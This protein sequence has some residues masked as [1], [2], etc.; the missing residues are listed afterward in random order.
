M[1]RRL[2]R[3][4][5]FALALAGAGPA[6]AAAF[7][8]RAEEALVVDHETGATLLAKNADVAVPPASMLKLMTLNM[9][10]EALKEGR[11]ALDDRFPVS[12]KA[13]R[14]GGSKMFLR[15]GERPT[16]EELI[17]GVVVLSGNDACVVLAE[18]LAG[19]EA[20]FAE[21]MTARARELGMED[22]RFGNSTGWPAPDTEMSPRDLVFLAR[23]I[24]REFPEYYEYFAE[25]SY[26][27]DDIEQRNRNP[28]LYADLGADGLKTGHTEEA[29]YGLVGSAIRDGRRIVFMVGGYEDRAARATEAERL[30]EWAFREFSNETLFRAGEPLGEA[31]V[32]LGASPRV[33]LTVAE[34]LK[35]TV[36]FGERDEVRARIVWEGPLEAPIRAGETVAEMSVEAPGLAPVSVPVVAAEDVAEGGWTVRLGAAG[37][38]LIRDLSGLRD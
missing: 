13:W 2:A 38:L 3:I 17:R 25:T 24:I 8:L 20:A 15:A 34:D 36:P 37:R 29:G 33:G 18:G 22:S 23:R 1:K 26:V 30:V 31:E 21:R 27:W 28:L 32:W 35:A 4:L 14:M 16:V 7:D 6:S 5:V 10:F 12:E 9:V 11:L 19:T